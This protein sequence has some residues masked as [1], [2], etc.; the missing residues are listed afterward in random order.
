[1]EPALGNPRALGYLQEGTSRQRAAYRTMRRLDVMAELARFDPVLVSTVCVGLD[2]AE[3]DLD[4]ACSFQHRE[5]FEHEVKAAYENQPDFQLRCWRK[6]EYPTAV[7][8]FDT[9]AFPIEIFGRARP[10]EQQL[11]WRHFRIM[12]RL[13]KAGGNDLRRQVHRLKDTGMSTEPA[14]VRHLGIEDGKDPYRTLLELENMTDGELQRL[15]VQV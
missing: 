11:G 6:A 14:L 12:Q 2:T 10:I 4:V 13:V 15:C 3:S 8:T 9:D 1:M 7:A 5:P